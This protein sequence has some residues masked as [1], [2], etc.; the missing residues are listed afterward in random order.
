MDF[1]EISHRFPIDFPYGTLEIFKSSRISWEVRPAPISTNGLSDLG[2]D[3]NRVDQ[4]GQF[5]LLEYFWM[6]LDVYFNT[7][8][9]WASLFNL[10]YIIG[11]RFIQLLDPNYPHSPLGSPHTPLPGRVPAPTKYSLSTWHQ[12]LGD[13]LTSDTRLVWIGIV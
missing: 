13:R 12:T 5:I 7:G 2:R 9:F 6:I 4:Q 10:I 11:G 8:L 3:G 1:P